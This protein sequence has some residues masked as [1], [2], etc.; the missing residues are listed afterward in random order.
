MYHVTTGSESGSSGGVADFLVRGYEKNM[1]DDD[2]LTLLCTSE[3]VFGRVSAG[4][5]APLQRLFGI[6]YANDQQ[7][8]NRRSQK[9]EL[10]GAT[11]AEAVPT[12]RVNAVLTAAHRG[13][14]GGHRGVEVEGWGL[15]VIMHQYAWLV[16]CV[17]DREIWLAP[18][19][20]FSPFS[21]QSIDPPV[22]QKCDGQCQE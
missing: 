15:G 5:P 22:G 13:E 3:G 12:L 1:F 7:W 18:T 10:R 2:M 9:C 4:L 21:G 14:G 6:D 8:Q 11:Q 16:V 17:L 20:L 19:Y